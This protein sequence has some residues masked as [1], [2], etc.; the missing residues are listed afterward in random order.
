MA[1]LSRALTIHCRMDWMAISSYGSGTK[2]SGVVRILKDLSS[3]IS[4]VDVLVVEDN[5]EIGQFATQVL[6]D[7][8]YRTTWAAN[9]LEALEVVAEQPAAFD[10][11]FS[12]VVMPGI[13][14]IELGQEIRRRYPGLPV[15]LTSGYS[16]VLA[17][18][19]AHGFELLRKPYSVE[20][21]SRT[22]RK[23]TAAS[24]L[25]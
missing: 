5:V 17:N 21:L 12:D 15:I 7:L 6:Q 1:D 8:G 23:A 18:D 11:V 25:R 9:A 19:G 22:L 2:S 13:S 3:D 16:H 24:D 10:V 4:G 20:Q 14:G